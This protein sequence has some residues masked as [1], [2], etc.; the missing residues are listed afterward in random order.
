MR[1]RHELHDGPRP[2]SARTAGPDSVV[3]GDLV[4]DLRGREVR[5]RGNV[6]QLTRIE[7]DILA[8]LA[9][10]P[11]WVVSPDQLMEEVWGYSSFGDTRAISVH[12][13]NLRRKLGDDPTRAVYIQTVRGAGYKVV[14]PA[15]AQE[16]SAVRDPPALPAEPAREPGRPAAPSLSSGFVGRDREIAALTDAWSQ[17]R[18]GHGGIVLLSGEA[19]IGKTRLASELADR[20]GAEGAPVAWGRC[21]EA[22]GLPAYWPWIQSLRRLVRDW[23]DLGAG[24]GRGASA[25]A[26]IIP[27]L[28]DRMTPTA[29]EGADSSAADQGLAGTRDPDP[30]DRERFFRA[31]MDFLNWASDR[32]PAL[33]VLDDLHLADAGS[34]L[35]LESL[36]CELTLS[37]A[38]VVGTYRDAGKQNGHPLAR[39]VAALGR[40]GCL[41]LP[42]AGLPA[43]AVESVMAQSAGMAI[44]PALGREIQSRTA[45]NPLFVVEL[46]R[47]LAIEG[48]LATAEPAAL[49]SL[50]LPQGV[51]GVL[52]RHISRLSAETR[53]LLDLA[54]LLGRSIDRLVLA[55]ASGLA[56]DEMLRLLDEAI[57]ARLLERDPATDRYRFVHPL[58]QEAL[59]ADRGE[60]ERLRLHARIGEALEAHSL[61]DPDGFLPDLAYHFSRAAPLGYGPRAY[62][63]SRLAAESAVSRYGYEEAAEHFTRALSLLPCSGLDA[64]DLRAE[65]AWLHEQTGDA[66]ALAA[67]R[68][69]AIH[70]FRRA[71]TL[72]PADEVVARARLERKTG[73][74]WL[75]DQE[76]ARA[77]AS[78]NNAE[79]ILGPGPAQVEDRADRN[80][81]PPDDDW[82]RERIELAL[83][84]MALL[85]FTG[86]LDGLTT[87][88]DDIRPL[89]EG[90]G[91]PHQ[92]GVFASHYLALAFRQERYRVSPQ[93]VAFAREHHARLHRS[94]DGALGRE[95]E[96]QLGFALLWTGA[97]D[98]AEVHLAR[99]AQLAADAR[100]HSRLV[101]AS[102]YLTALHRLRGHDEPAQMW[103]GLSR[104]RAADAHLLGY[105]GA[106]A[107]TE[108]WVALRR[109]DDGLAEQLSMEA[110]ELWNA[111]SAFPFEWLARGPLL[112]L[113]CARGDLEAGVLN[114][115]ALLA[116]TQ[117]LLP[118]DLSAPLTNAART[119]RS[120]PDSAA[121]MGH[122]AAALAAAPV[123]FA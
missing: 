103:A 115:E 86:D 90:G 45:G 37:S 97:L 99:C 83:Q 113:A 116:S 53:A 21:Q 24:G 108:A 22:E 29:E 81:P 12:I 73:E 82:T 118:I 72:L 101:R 75:T 95:A 34:L 66:L 61:T 67:L 43:D 89:V 9:A 27:E 35:L 30:A 93:T 32:R 105:V 65:A 87:L 69:D 80:S 78:F 10:H 46:T 85:Y 56:G 120:S 100:D 14:N 47:L 18:R 25:L 112:R 58:V 7:F 70:A 121:T 3:V 79:T 26:A 48:R 122:L 107:A 52:E 104:Q 98:E 44:A 20:V 92:Q 60:A 33:L 106:A 38:L 4:I 19:G 102:T 15:A 31:V 91:T 110:L 94:T 11:G 39:T 109:E 5:V 64:G 68:R 1:D 84:R 6:A 96:Y 111:P 114:A 119:W 17:A 40:A 8:Y 16:R 28:R 23:P 42:L 71:A 77:Q 51:R 55:D 76:A 50:A 54:A 59:V 62:G 123:G 49:L 117:Q 74:T 36:A 57:A 63:Y 13:G 2:S 88:A 41:H